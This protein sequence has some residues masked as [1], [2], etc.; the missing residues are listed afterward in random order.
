M[1]SETEMCNTFPKSQFDMKGYSAPFKRDQT[2][3]G[4][5]ILLY[6]TDE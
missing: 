2:S 4:G 5:G 1:V 3:Q 6:I